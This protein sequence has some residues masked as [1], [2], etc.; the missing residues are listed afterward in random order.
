MDKYAKYYFENPEFKNL[1]DKKLKDGEM[2]GWT[3]IDKK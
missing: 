1:F 2:R 3:T